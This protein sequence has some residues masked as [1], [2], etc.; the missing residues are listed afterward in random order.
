MTHGVLS[1]RAIQK[2]VREGAIFIDPFTPAQLNPV[3]YDLTLGEE[4]RVYEDVNYLH[5]EVSA[6]GTFDGRHIQPLTGI[7]P[8]THYLDSKKPNPT[9]SFKIKDE[10]WLLKP[11]VGYLMHTHERVRTDHFVPVV[12]G[13]SS[14]GRLFIAVHVT[15][16]YIDPGFDGCYTLEVMALHPVKVYARQR[17]CQVRFHTIMGEVTLYDGH[18]KGD[19]AKGAVAS[20]SYEQFEDK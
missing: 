4:V 18:Y 11:G 17:I 14:I 9:K 8:G 20:H 10:G 2:A 15:A 16:G 1:G 12:D 13:K 7:H 3:S 6:P 19:T 5:E